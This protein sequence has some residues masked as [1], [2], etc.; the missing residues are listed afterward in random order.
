MR[1]IAHRGLL[2]G[3]DQS[4]ENYPDQIRQVIKEGFDAEIDLRVIEDELWLGHDEPQYKI[5]LEWLKRF[6]MHLWIHCK[7][8]EALQYCFNIPSLNYFAHDHDDYVVT[9]K[10][11]V[12]AYPGK[13]GG[14]FTVLVMPEHKAML[15]QVIEDY[16]MDVI[17][18]YGVC[19]D[20]ALKV[21]NETKRNTSW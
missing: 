21:R 11:Y 20:F 15:D 17:A 2:E 8:L 19:T 7:N 9:S 1:I 12:W 5:N 18:P 3:P 4:C 6:A 10:G 13:P 14:K 16:N